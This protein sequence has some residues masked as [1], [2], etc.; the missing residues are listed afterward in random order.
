[1]LMPTGGWW[2]E[3]G[4]FSGSEG[5]IEFV[6]G[7]ASVGNSV[8]TE[9]TKTQRI[10]VTAANVSAYITRK[11]TDATS[12]AA[13]AATVAADDDGSSNQRRVPK[14]TSP[15]HRTS[16][17]PLIEELS[18]VRLVMKTPLRKVEG[19]LHG[20]PFMDLEILPVEGTVHLG[21]QPADT[22]TIMALWF[23]NM[24]RNY[25]PPPDLA[26]MALE[27]ETTKGM[28]VRLSLEQV[29]IWMCA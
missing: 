14:P 12:T 23:D 5:V 26:K 3:N 16:R 2:G 22:R 19:A 15:K 20:Q 4:A 24:S 11:W 9:P 13:D 8:L 10:A 27:R 1:M 25:N 6:I 29:V 28:A 7:K 18:E 17:L 21:L